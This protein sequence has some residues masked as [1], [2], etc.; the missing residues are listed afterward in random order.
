MLVSVVSSLISG[1]VTGIQVTGAANSAYVSDSTITRNTTGLVYV[2]SGTAVSGTDNR[3]V[4][5][6]NPSAFSSSVS[7]L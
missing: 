6:T 5:N 2:T 4:N 7:K 3:L 1:N